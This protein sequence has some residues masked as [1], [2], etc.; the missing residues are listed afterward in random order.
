[1]TNRCFSRS[2]ILF[3][4]IMFALIRIVEADDESP[5]KASGQ[6]GKDL[7]RLVILSRLVADKPSLLIKRPSTQL[8]Q[9]LTA[10]PFGCLSSDL[11][12]CLLSQIS[13]VLLRISGTE[14]IFDATQ[15]A[16]V[17]ITFNRATDVWP[18]KDISNTWDDIK[19]WTDAVGP[20]AVIV[21][22]LMLSQQKQ[23][24]SNHLA[25]DIIGSG[26]A[27]II[28]G[29]LG[30]L[31]QFFGGVNYKERA[32]SAKKTIDKLQ[33]IEKSRQA[34]EDSQLIYGFL[35]SYSNQS[36]K[37][38]NTILTLSSDAKDLN[39][40]APSPAKS[41]KI[42]ALCD[43]ASEVV[44][45]FKETADLT[46]EYA[47]QLLHLY[48]IYRDEVS[49]PDDKQ[50]F[51]DAQQLVKKFIDKYDEVIVPYVQGAPEAI[52]AMQNVKAAFI[53]NSIADKQYF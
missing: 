11:S 3:L 31:G 40:L 37:L 53:A 7:K 29:D 33:D 30:T 36:K 5:L 47:I 35:D 14:N 26:A 45:N 28:V 21:G 50:K 52:E 39:S 44:S 48:K 51:E 46:K 24:S 22:A 6:W 12:E 34:Y 32:Q 15:G 10:E 13:I 27:L 42:V 16:S 49:L 43:K 25:Q 19:K 4:F 41:Q 38:L 18:N 23:G 2:I 17:R 9:E 1:M 8:I 20:A